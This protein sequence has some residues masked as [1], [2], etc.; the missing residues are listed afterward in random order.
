MIITRKQKIIIWLGTVILA[1]NFL[2]PPWAVRQKRG[3]LTDRQ[4][5]RSFILTP[6]DRNYAQVYID[7]TLLVTS[8]I[9]IA[10]VAGVLIGL[11]L[12]PANFR[13]ALKVLL[14]LLIICVAGLLATALIL[15]TVNER[16]AAQARA[17]E[18]QARAPEVQAREPE[19]QSLLADRMENDPWYS[20]L[21]EACRQR[22]SRLMCSGASWEEI[23]VTVYPDDPAD[24]NGMASRPLQ[25]GMIPKERF[26]R[27]LEIEYK[28]RLRG[29]KDG[30]LTYLLVISSRAEKRAK[31][32]ENPNG[33]QKLAE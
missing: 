21:D 6:P 15:N 2:Y 20:S 18:A 16:K 17:R 28:L 33:L 32:K 11:S 26:L 4:V 29:D 23:E 8:S 19:V 27:A 14:L 30:I 24:D 3:T 25:P 9:A 31:A 10:L 1:A 7:A 5:M 22:I 12:L 13:K